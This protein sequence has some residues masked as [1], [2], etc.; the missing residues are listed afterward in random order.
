M[1]PEFVSE[2]WAMSPIPVGMRPLLR[3]HLESLKPSEVMAV[4][5][6]WYARDP[7][8]LERFIKPLPAAAR[9]ALRDHLHRN[10]MARLIRK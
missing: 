3:K 10:Y 8:S 2:F 5:A 4:I 7:D 1:T 6:S 9:A